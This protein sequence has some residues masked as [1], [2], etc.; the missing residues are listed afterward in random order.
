MCGEA[1]SHTT[2]ASHLF[3]GRKQRGGV[4]V[5]PGDDTRARLRVGAETAQLAVAQRRGR[6]RRAS[7]EIGMQVDA[8]EQESHRRVEPLR[9]ASRSD[10]HLGERQEKQHR[11][12]KHG[13]QSTV[14]YEH[15]TATHGLFDAEIAGYR[16]G[17]HTRQYQ[18]DLQRRRRHDVVA[19][20]VNERR[21][22]P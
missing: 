12:G 14:R 5:A 1:Q 7:S 19:F 11:E 16:H 8:L 2:V 22:M 10:Q 21:R 20:Q 9:Q 18:R 4:A 3:E 13:Q 17:I 6:E 15:A